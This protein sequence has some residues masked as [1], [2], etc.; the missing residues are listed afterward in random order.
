MPHVPE[1]KFGDPRGIDEAA[2]GFAEY[3]NDIETELV[4]IG[5]TQR[6]ARH[7]DIDHHNECVCCFRMPPPMTILTLRAL[8]SIK[9][10]TPARPDKAD[11]QPRQSLDV[12]NGSRSSKRPREPSD[13][14]DAFAVDA[15]VSVDRTASC[16]GAAHSK[17]AKLR[18]IMA[19]ARGI[20]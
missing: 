8:L 7:V 20:I 14:D 17:F 3:V 18:K 1:R 9:V 6:Q 15:P 13:D 4:Q 11:E 16:S 10:A 5:N 19:A 12:P 2:T